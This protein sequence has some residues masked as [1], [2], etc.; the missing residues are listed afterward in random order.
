M[1][2]MFK[3]III[4]SI[5]C[6]ITSSM[7]FGDSATIRHYDRNSNSTG[8]SKKSPDGSLT[9]Y[10]NHNSEYTGYARNEDSKTLYYD[11]KEN[12]TGYSI[13]DPNRSTTKYYD[14]NSSYTGLI[15]PHT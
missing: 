9:K 5:I 7:C 14:R 1:N 6:L 13:N 3:R 4:F 2:A 10:Y 15:I 11:S 8:Y 12:Y